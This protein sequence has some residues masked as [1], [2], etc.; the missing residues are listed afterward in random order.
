MN[1]AE[2]PAEIEG[3]AKRAAE[4]YG[5][6]G[7]DSAPQSIWLDGVKDAIVTVNGQGLGQTNFEQCACTAIREWQEA[8]RAELDA[9]AEETAEDDK[10][11]KKSAKKK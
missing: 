11:A 7:W 6:L 4:L 3:V 10:P 8:K 2:F 5:Q 9:A 1:L